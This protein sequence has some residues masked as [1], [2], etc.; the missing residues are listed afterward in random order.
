MLWVISIELIS[1]TFGSQRV[2]ADMLKVTGILTWTSKQTFGES[3][4]G[5]NPHGG[6]SII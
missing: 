5:A 3:I 1:D 2:N 4:T 6:V